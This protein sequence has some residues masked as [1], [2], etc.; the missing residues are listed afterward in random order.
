MRWAA[1]VSSVRRV[2]TGSGLTLTHAIEG[3]VLVCVGLLPLAI[4][5]ESAMMGFIQ[6]PKM[7]V[8]RSIA[9]VLAVL[10]ALEWARPDDRRALLDE[11]RELPSAMRRYLGAQPIVLAASAVLAVTVLAVLFSPIRSI[12]ISGRTPGYDTYGLYSV[13][14]YLVLFVAVLRHVR[15]ESQVRRLLWTITGTAILLSAYGIGQRFG[16]DWFRT[17]P[18]PQGRILLTFGNPVFGAA[19]LLMTIPLTLG[20]WQRWRERFPAAVHALLGAALI[21]TQLTA[22][23]ATLGRGAIV[24]L[25]VGMLAL[26]GLVVW[27]LGRKASFSPAA[28][29]GVVVLAALVLSYVPVPGAPDGI[30]SLVERLAS[31]SSSLTPGGDALGDR[32]PIWNNALTAYA[33]TPWPDTTM[34]PE[35]PEQG[36]LP[37][38][39]VLG[40]G[41]DMF[42]YAYNM[43]GDSTLAAPPVHG[44]NFAMHTLVELGLA[45]VLA[46]A[47]LIAT[48]SAGL[49]RS[50]VA[51]R[52]GLLPTWQS[53]LVISLAS[54]FVA[55]LVEQLVGKAQTSDLALSWVLA[56]MVVAL[57]AMQSLTAPG[58]D[59]VVV[60]EGQGSRRRGRSGAGAPISL[61]RAVIVGVLVLPALV[62]WWTTV[63]APVWSANLAARGQQAG[64]PAS[65]GELLDRAIDAAPDAIAPRMLF[66]TGLLNSARESDAPEERMTLL[67]TAVG[68]L[69][70]VLDRD[71]MNTNARIALARIRREIA[72]TDLSF[73]EIA[74][75]ENEL[76][77]TLVSGLW[78]RREPF[79]R[80]LVAL[81]EFDRALAEVALAKKLGAAGLD[82][83][84][85]NPQ[86]YALYYL[87]AKA[88]Q[89]L[90]RNDEAQHIIDYLGLKVPFPEVGPLIDDL[91]ESGT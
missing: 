82:S 72:M 63:L 73:K 26:L 53:W 35:I 21:V 56:G 12:G 4:M 81:G 76:V 51:A 42:G 44:H 70:P 88:L 71:P 85:L 24:G 43:V 5:P 34:F 55:R 46:Y 28:S 38:R 75:H 10:L 84:G 41:P 90:G 69:Q 29:L 15:S 30:S 8:L 47:A 67:R 50:L 1:C 48:M 59:S 39:R 80:T 61:P 2:H 62:F 57:P 14:P 66:S 6:V 31:V 83:W 32:L 65:V 49:Y 91:L 78:K 19:Y 27:T 86:A 37:I 17:N 11:L 7:F 77:V 89:E 20:L 87:E 3:T 18:E 23:S 40:F 16:V 60:G 22:L 52:R 33:S 45:G 36:L 25:G 9:L 68:V 58:G 74:I 54:V 13:V 64:N 79:V